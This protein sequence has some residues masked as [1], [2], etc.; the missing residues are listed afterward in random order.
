MFL[1][2]AGSIAL[3]ACSAYR[4]YIAIETGLRTVNREVG[5]VDCLEAGQRF[6]ERW[7]VAWEHCSDIRRG[8]PVNDRPDLS[9]DTITGRYQWGGQPK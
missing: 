4:P 6:T 2:V 7:S 8:S 9:H 1:A 5:R 3:S